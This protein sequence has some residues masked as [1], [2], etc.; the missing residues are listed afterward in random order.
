[1]DA[2]PY[3]AARER[4]SVSR[5]L[6]QIGLY[7]VALLAF[8][9]GRTDAGYILNFNSL[10]AG[11]NSAT[12]TDGIETYIES[13]IGS[14]VTVYDGTT[15][16]KEKPENVGPTNYLGNTDNGVFH[17][18]PKDTYLINRWNAG[19]P[20]G[21]GDRIKIT[22]DIGVTAID[23]DW[24]IFPVTTGKA[25][26]TLKADGVQYLYYDNSANKTNG[27]LS[28][29][30]IAFGKTVYTLE[31][32]DWTTAP[33]GIDNLKVTMAPEPSTGM[34]A[35]LGMAGMGLVRRKRTAA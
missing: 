10:A 26:F 23:F 3:C 14:N 2:S 4:G 22:F 17:A 13:V 35:V 30:T 15:T 1:M 21:V 6:R 29:S 34:L 19:L 31:F 5:G 16:L 20:A 18:N 9:G 33:V 32:I 28:H 7:S 11:V 12:G 25:D 8:A 24:Q 27:Y